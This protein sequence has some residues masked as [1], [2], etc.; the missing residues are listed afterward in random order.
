MSVS[1]RWISCGVL[2]LELEE[3]FR[4]GKIQGE[5][6]F[7]DSMLHMVPP[8]LGTLL[9]RRLEQGAATEGRTVVVYGDCCPRM[10]NLVQE[11]K[12]GRVHAINCAQMLVGKERYRELMRER[13]FMMLPEWARRWKDVFRKELGLS[14]NVARDL[15]GDN[16]GKIVYLDTGLLPVPEADLQ[17][18]SEYTGLAWRVEKV[19]LDAMLEML[20]EAESA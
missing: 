20:L 14:R 16:R 4:Q 12:V 2:R 10:L 13:A 7:L 18:C 1:T 8:Q 3:L 17:D 6:V 19:G 11:H 5:L 15:M 9:Q